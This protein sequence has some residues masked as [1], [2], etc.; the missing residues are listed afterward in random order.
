MIRQITTLTELNEIRTDLHIAIADYVERSKTNMDT[1]SI[2]TD[3]LRN[4]NNPN[5]GLL[6][7]ENNDTKR[8]QGFCIL[9]VKRGKLG[10]FFCEIWAVY[11]RRDTPKDIWREGKEF[12]REWARQRNCKEFEMW[13]IRSP[14][15]WIEKLKQMGF[16]DDWQAHAVVLR[17]PVEGL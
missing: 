1:V 14:K 2:M 17:K 13:S 5:T 3:I 8:F 10:Y 16:G 9:Q 6:V 4:L 7:S 12:I 11:I 15:A